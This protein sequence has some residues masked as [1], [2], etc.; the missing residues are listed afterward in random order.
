MPAFVPWGS[1]EPRTRQ[2]RLAQFIAAAA[3]TAL[4][5]GC[6]GDTT[7]DGGAIAWS[8]PASGATSAAPTTA[9]S[10]PPLN[11]QTRLSGDIVTVEIRDPNDYYRVERVELVGPNGMTIAAHEIN[12]TTNRASGDYYGGYGGSNVGVGIG[13]WGGSRS[14]AGVGIGLDFPLGGSSAPPPQPIGTV[15]TA[16]M[17]IPDPA[18]YRQTASQWI[19]RV[20]LTDRG[21]QPQ[22]AVIPAPR[23]AG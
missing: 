14:G 10:G 18:F 7:R 4:I 20:S 9:P 3:F 11:W 21:N 16:S 8:D 15:T 13:G 17:R 2:A 6:A 22:A 1:S 5:A 23:P 12:R 19:V